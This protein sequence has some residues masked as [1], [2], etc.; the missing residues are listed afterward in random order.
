MAGLRACAR[1]QQA[2]ERAGYT[3]EELENLFLQLA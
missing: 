2:A 1:D 3:K